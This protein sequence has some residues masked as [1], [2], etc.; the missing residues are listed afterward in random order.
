MAK[1]NTDISITLLAG[2]ISRA[3]EIRVLGLH[4]HQHLWMDTALTKLRNIREQVGCMIRRVSHK[5][6]EIQCIDLLWLAHAF[7]TSRVVYSVPY[8][9]LRKN[10][11]IIKKAIKCTPDLQISTSNSPLKALG[12]I[13]SCQELREAHLLNQYTRLA[14]TVWPMPA[15]TSA[16]KT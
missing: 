9:S 10:E 4:I 11:A 13:D 16:H 8:L 7:V 1:D 14:P 12:V 3:E 2:P 15:C 6:R 5:R